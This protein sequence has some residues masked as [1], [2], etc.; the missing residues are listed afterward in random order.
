MPD[1]YK[2]IALITVMMVVAMVSATASWL[3]LQQHV[4]LRR[5]TNV[6]HEE[7]AILLSLGVETYVR[8]LLTRD[9]RNAGKSRV[10]YYARYD[11]ES[12][13]EWWSKQGTLDEERVS[14][15][16]GFERTRSARLTWCVFDLSAY[17]NVNNL[18]FLAL[19]K[20]AKE[21]PKSVR[22]KSQAERD[23]KSDNA[24][25]DTGKPTSD[26]ETEKDDGK[27]RVLTTKQWERKMFDTLYGGSE[28]KWASLMDWFD[29][30]NNTRH[31]G[32][33]D[34]YYLDLEPPYRASG[35]RM[36]YPEEL[37]LVKG[38]TPRS[39][40]KNVVALPSVK[41]TKINV[42]TASR[43]MLGHI[44]SYMR[45]SLDGDEWSDFL[46]QRRYSPFRDIDSFY[47]R[48]IGYED[49]RVTKASLAWANKFLDVKS[50]YFLAVIQISLGGS[51][52]YMQ[53]VLVRDP[54]DPYDVYVLQ[55][56]LG[57]V[58]YSRRDCRVD[59]PIIVEEE[60]KQEDVENSV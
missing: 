30:D 54:Q 41:P 13:S 25:T 18:R 14:V 46:K 55:R 29:H 50:D 3:M 60:K 43:E 44:L 51:G 45:I 15:L 2:G 38:F 1:R 17:H 52:F 8:E 59:N 34:P 21:K 33:E 16:F 32:G 58:E 27:S 48:L 23:K 20:E 31:E 37:G 35:M 26:S 47:S 40:N 53:S 36:V 49:E 6:V 22:E 42:N 11:D 24:D 10:D 19:S 12:R 39:V 5:V 9:S 7:Q 57:K 56:K 4:A 28:E